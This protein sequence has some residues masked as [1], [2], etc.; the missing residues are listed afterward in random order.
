MS[1]S[2][3]WSRECSSE[4]FRSSDGVGKA[5]AYLPAFAQRSGD[6]GQEDNYKYREVPYVTGS[7]YP[8]LFPFTSP[9]SI[10]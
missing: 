3:A 9:L 5:V 2:R 10:S 4:L 1:R 7:H 8:D 6:A